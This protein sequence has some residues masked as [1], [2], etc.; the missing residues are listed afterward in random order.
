MEKWKALTV[1]PLLMS[2]VPAP[3]AVPIS[4]RPLLATNCEPLPRTTSADGPPGVS[5]N[6]KIEPSLT[7]NTPPPVIAHCELLMDERAS[8]ESKNPAV[9]IL[10]AAPSTAILPLYPK[11]K[12]CVTTFP[13]L[14]TSTLP[15]PLS[16]TVNDFV[17]VTIASLVPPLPVTLRLP[18]LFAF[19][20]STTEGAVKVA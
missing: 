17:T 9:V 19:C 13:P 10:D 7:V 11:L 20:P 5:T 4:I 8:K 14:E 12:N 18:L 16:P 2:A 1:P 3:A 15:V 6:S